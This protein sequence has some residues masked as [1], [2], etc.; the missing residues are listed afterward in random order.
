MSIGFLTTIT[1]RLQVN[2]KAVSSTHEADLTLLDLLR[3]ELALN[4]TKRGCDQGACGACTV[5]VDGKRIV[6]CLTLAA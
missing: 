6:S 3:E 1:T 2:G 5:L 4:G